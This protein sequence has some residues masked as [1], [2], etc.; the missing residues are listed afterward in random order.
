MKRFVSML[1][2][3]ALSIAFAGCSKNPP[4][5]LTIFSCG[6]TVTAAAQP[7]SGNDSRRPA[8]TCV[9]GGIVSAQETGFLERSIS[10]D[11]SEYLYR[12]YVPPEFQRAKP[13]PI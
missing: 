4:A 2:A 8:G 9:G 6:L 5:L 12:V 10:I 3:S 1:I 7:A 13:S 11:G